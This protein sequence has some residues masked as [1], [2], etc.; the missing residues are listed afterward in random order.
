MK[1][2]L[3]NITKN[4]SKNQVL[5]GAS[6]VFEEGRVYGLLGRNG[7]GK[8][9]L[10]NCISGDL[11]ADKGNVF[12][13]KGGTAFPAVQEDVGYLPSSPILPGFLTGL[14]FLKFYIDINQGDSGA[15]RIA[16]D[17]FDM[18]RFRAEDRSSLIRGYSHGMKSMLQM[19]CFLISTP[20]V[21]LLDEPVQCDDPDMTADFKNILNQIREHHVILLST[22]LPELAEELCDE[23]AI[24]KNGRID[25]AG[26]SILADPKYKE[27]IAVLLREGNER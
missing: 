18:I 13:L 17:Y 26:P 3:K 21:I 1:L 20:P 16:D 11:Q 2:E 14:E 10:L 22:H 6:A 27:K 5:K 7:S 12:L 25:M 23:I 15:Y 4:F 8:T 9:T 24:L 19:L